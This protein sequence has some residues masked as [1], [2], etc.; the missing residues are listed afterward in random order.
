MCYVKV[1]LNRTDCV[2][3]FSQ[4]LQFQE[5]SKEIIQNAFSHC[6]APARCSQLHNLLLSSKA[7]RLLKLERRLSRPIQ[8]SMSPKSRHLHLQHARRALSSRIHLNT[9]QHN[10]DDR[11]LQGLQI[12]LRAISVYHS[13]LHPLHVSH[14]RRKTLS[15]RWDLRSITPV[16]LS[17]QTL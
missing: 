12:S 7:T 17:E 15:R 5:G 8:E 13:G 9:I 4:L 1:S 16:S 3:L 6:A 10:P 11:R 2:E 14:R